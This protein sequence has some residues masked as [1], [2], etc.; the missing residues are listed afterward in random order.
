M[1]G[2]LNV[3]NELASKAPIPYVDDAIANVQPVSGGSSV[4]KNYVSPL[5]ASLDRLNNI[6][7]IEVE[8]QK[9]HKS[10][11][12]RNTVLHYQ[13]LHLLRGLMLLG[14]L[15]THLLLKHFFF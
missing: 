10:N 9:D 5:D 3:N 8:A 15:T 14:C 13:V 6:V 1:L 12:Q 11:H 4:L 7:E 2:N